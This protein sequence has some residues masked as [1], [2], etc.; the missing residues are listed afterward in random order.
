MF[1]E[2]ECK[3]VLNPEGIVFKKCENL[4]CNHFGIEAAYHQFSINIHSLREFLNSEYI[5]NVLLRG[6]KFNI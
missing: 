3:I 2:N 4:T 5:Q 1:I 6:V